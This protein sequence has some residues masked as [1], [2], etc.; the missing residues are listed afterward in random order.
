[1]TLGN[2]RTNS[3]NALIA[4]CLNPDCRHKADVVVD[5]RRSANRDAARLAHGAASR[6]R[7]ADTVGRR[8]AK[9]FAT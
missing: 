3:V 4:T 7:R 1:M 6:D 8:I 9:Q 2:M 5:V